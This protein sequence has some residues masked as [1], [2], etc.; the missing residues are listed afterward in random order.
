ML[1]LADISSLRPNLQNYLACGN[2]TSQNIDFFGLNAYEWCGSTPTYQ[3]S[4]YM[5]LDTQV[6]DLPIPIFFSETGCNAPDPRTFQ[7]QTA[8][9]GVMTPNWSGA[10]IYEWIQ[11]ENHYGKPLSHTTYT[12]RCIVC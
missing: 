12:H 2:V 6:N 5:S 1:H 10:I 3:T 9:F 7:D 8:I 4:G 11:E